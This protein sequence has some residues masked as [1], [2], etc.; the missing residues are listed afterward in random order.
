MSQ[1]R[2][3][4]LQLVR[5]AL[6]DSEDRKEA[7]EKHLDRAHAARREREL[8]TKRYWDMIDQAISRAKRKEMI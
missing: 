1:T 7:V 8:G 4:T 5:S 2:E 6:G 3:R